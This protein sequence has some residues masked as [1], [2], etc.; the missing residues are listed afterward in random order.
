LNAS[1]KSP[2]ALNPKVFAGMQTMP[3]QVGDRLRCPERSP[4]GWRF[5]RDTGIAVLPLFMAAID[6]AENGY[7][8]TPVIG[9]S[10]NSLVETYRIIRIGKNFFFDGKPPKI[11]EKVV[12]KYHAR[13]LKQLWRQKGKLTTGRNRGKNVAHSRK[14]ADISAWKIR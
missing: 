8:L 14:T 9:A 6:Y 10:W 4:P 13:T 2:K 7:L 11:G 1:G 3:S 12:F 5:M